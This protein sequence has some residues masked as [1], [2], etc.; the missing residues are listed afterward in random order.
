[1]PKV[2]A[3]GVNFFYQQ[4]GE[5]PDLLLVHGITGNMAVWMLSGLTQK[6]ARQF[7]VTAY[8]MR[9]HG[10]SDTPQSTILLQTWRK[11]CRPSANSLRSV[12]SN[13]WGTVLE[14]SSRYMPRTNFRI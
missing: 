10:Y 14:Q 11:M 1:M 12:K 13:C 4:M 7:R 5:G 2:K 8:D 9:G 6:L 3:R